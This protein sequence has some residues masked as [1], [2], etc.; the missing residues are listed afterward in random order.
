MPSASEVGRLII[1]GMVIL[2]VLGIVGY[3]MIMLIGVH[4]GPMFKHLLQGSGF[5]DLIDTGWSGWKIVFAL[6]LIIFF[7]YIIFKIFYEREPTTVGY[8]GGY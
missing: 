5:E 7:G 4:T 1:E 3:V 8:Q 6:V 2:T